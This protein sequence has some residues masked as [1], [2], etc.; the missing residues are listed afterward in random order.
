MP[1]AVP[2]VDLVTNDAVIRNNHFLLRGRV[3]SFAFVHYLY[4]DL[5]VDFTRVRGAVGAFH[6]ELLGFKQNWDSVNVRNILNK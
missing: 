6:H 1:I 5:S 4:H 2:R 3:S